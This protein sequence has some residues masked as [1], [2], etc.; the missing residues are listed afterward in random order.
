MFQSK[1]EDD[2]IVNIF[3]ECERCVG[4]LLSEYYNDCCFAFQKRRFQMIKAA[5]S[6]WGTQ[7]LSFATLKHSYHFLGELSLQSD[8]EILPIR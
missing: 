7:P 1:K 6:C 3:Y 4:C 5:V 8:G 2:K